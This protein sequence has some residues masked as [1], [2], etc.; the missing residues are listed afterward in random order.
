MAE[1]GQFI[2]GNTLA[3]VLLDI[4][5]RMGQNHIL[6]GIMISENIG[7]CRMCLTQD[8]IRVAE[9]FR[10]KIQLRQQVFDCN[11]RR[12]NVLFI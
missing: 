1:I 5:D 2:Y 7:R 6:I 8:S 9:I 11:V 10:K 4:L 12:C 3:A